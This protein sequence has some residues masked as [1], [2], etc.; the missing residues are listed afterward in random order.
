MYHGT[1]NVPYNYTCQELCAA[2]ATAAVLDFRSEFGAGSSQED[3][4]SLIH[5]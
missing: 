5:I 1:W 2:H 4:L 3:D